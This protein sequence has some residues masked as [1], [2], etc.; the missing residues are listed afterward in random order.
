[1][2]SFV[3]DYLHCAVDFKM[4]KLTSW[5]KEYYVITKKCGTFCCNGPALQLC[6]DCAFKGLVYVVG[7][8]FYN[9][10]NFW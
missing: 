7:I 5:S 6:P 2:Q 10:L 4:Q 1:M 9:L 8:M 3:N